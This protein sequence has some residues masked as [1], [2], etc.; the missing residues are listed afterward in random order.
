V[1]ASLQDALKQIRLR[2]SEGPRRRPAVAEL[3]S[4]G[5]P[6]QEDGPTTDSD[7]RKRELAERGQPR[8]GPGD[9]DIEPFSHLAAGSF[10]GPGAHDA[11]CQA[12]LA[13]RDLQEGGFPCVRLQESHTQVAPRDK[14]RDS[15][16]AR[17]TPDVD[18]RGSLRNTRTQA[19][20]RI[21]DVEARRGFWIRDCGEPRVCAPAS[22]QIEVARE[23]L[24]F[25]RCGGEADGG[26][27][28]LKDGPE[29][30]RRHC[31]P[32]HVRVHRLQ[33]PAPSETP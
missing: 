28:R 33:A 9:G 18:Q 15:G 6:L 3:G 26:D 12:K 13:R 4:D 7:E 16:Q 8:H 23:E 25:L 20:Q 30:V 27:L 31:P 11:G 22:D 19:E 14:Q 29:P 24:E 17:S 32:G 5:R 2:S 10:L 21:R 1:L